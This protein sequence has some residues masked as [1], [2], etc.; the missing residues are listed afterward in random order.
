MF[1]N[2]KFA[3]QNAIVEKRKQNKPNFVE[4]SLVMPCVSMRR[5]LYV[6]L[7]QDKRLT[8]SIKTEG[9]SQMRVQGLLLPYAARPPGDTRH[10]WVTPI[11]RSKVTFEWPACGREVIERMNNYHFWNDDIWY[12]MLLKI[13]LMG[14]Y[15]N[16]SR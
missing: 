9:E 5:F 8:F 11:A 6:G 1:S 12:K 14:G 15:L 2:H 16:G 13:R 3:C 10:Q 4:V 7:T